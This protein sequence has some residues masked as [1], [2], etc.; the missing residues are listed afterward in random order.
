[1]EKYGVIYRI[2][3]LINNKV[4]IG[5]T[6]QNPQRRWKEHL[7][8][9]ANRH[10]K[11][12]FDLYGRDSFKFEVIEECDTKEKLDEREQFYIAES[13]GNNYNFRSGGSHGLH[14]EET[15]KLLKIPKTKE[16]KE[17]IRQKAIGRKPCD[18]NIK[19]LLENV[20]SN[21]EKASKR[22]L[23][24]ETGI[25]YISA[26]EAIRQTGIQHIDRYCNRFHKTKGGYH[27]EYV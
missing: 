4:Y 23:C 5:Q 10:L 1:M 18:N 16:H 20:K 11:A 21:A 19:I 14:S 3:N 15:K 13:N 26:R 6:I 24:I 27:W 22:V 17:K 25:E 8:K 9:G 12:A 7:R 2:T